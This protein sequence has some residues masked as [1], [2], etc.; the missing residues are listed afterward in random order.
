MLGGN[1]KEI[2]NTEQKKQLNGNMRPKW[3]R[4]MCATC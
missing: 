1:I 3:R 4:V 2:Y